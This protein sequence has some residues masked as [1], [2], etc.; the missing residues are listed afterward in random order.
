MAGGTV[1]AG[2]ARG[3]RPPGASVDLRRSRSIRTRREIIEA[4]IELVESG[5]GQPTVAEVAEQAGISVRSIYWHF[6][7]AGL[8]FTTAAEL[9]SSRY[10][11]LIGHIPSHVPV[12]TRVL[13]L[14]RQRRRLFEAMDPVMRSGQGSKGAGPFLRVV[15]AECE[16]DLRHQLATALRPEIALF[17]QEGWFL[18]ESL[19]QA[20]GWQSWHR[21]RIESGRTATDA[22]RH[23]V[24]TVSTLLT[25]SPTP[26]DAPRAHPPS[27]HGLSL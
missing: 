24:F 19:H 21:L 16:S 27:D 23:M 12:A 15:L 5:N 6:G 20:T 4:V 9:Q 25:S 7:H 11:A 1:R 22:E 18:F 3:T 13:V 10:R 26:R 8:V 17:G 2:G 14:C